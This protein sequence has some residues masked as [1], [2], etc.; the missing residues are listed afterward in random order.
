MAITVTLIN[1]RWNHGVNVIV[2]LGP[3]NGQ[4]PTS[5]PNQKRRLNDG[6]EWPVA[7]SDGFDLWYRRDKDPDHPRVPPD[8]SNDLNHVVNFGTDVN[9]SVT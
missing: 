2:Y 5:F 7:V 9:E 1:D 8:Y 4:S 6:E 3:D